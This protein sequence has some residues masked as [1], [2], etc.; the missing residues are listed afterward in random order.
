[1]GGIEIVIA[2]NQA[3]I[4]KNADFRKEI[5]EEYLRKKL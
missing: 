5:I 2:E 3:T 1:M 4:R